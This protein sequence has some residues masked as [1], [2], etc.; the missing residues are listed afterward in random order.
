M[1]DI[2]QKI[3]DTI[4]NA[5]PEDILMAFILWTVFLLLFA[6]V[7]GVVKRDKLENRISQLEAENRELSKRSQEA[8]QELYN[9]VSSSPEYKKVPLSEVPPAQQ[10]RTP[11]VFADTYHMTGAYA[12]KVRCSECGLVCD[13]AELQKQYGYIRCPRCGKEFKEIIR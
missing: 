3:L 6:T 1:N 7:R 13:E 10:K 9:A 12:P 2:I 4:A 11:N 8:T 5:K